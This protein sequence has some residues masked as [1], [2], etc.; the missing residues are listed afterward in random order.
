MDLAYVN[1]PLDELGPLL[2]PLGELGSL[3]DQEVILL[4]L[5]GQRDRELGPHRA[6]TPLRRAGSSILLLLLRRRRAAVT[7][8]RRPLRRRHPPETAVALLPH[9]HLRRCRRCFRIPDKEN[10][11]KIQ[12]L[13]KRI[14]IHVNGMAKKQGGGDL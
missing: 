10:S 8:F 14:T 12:E 11:K 9:F 13:R 6:L 1:G 2:G 3:E 7:A 5:V 4:L